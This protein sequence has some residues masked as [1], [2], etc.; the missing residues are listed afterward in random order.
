MIELPFK[1]AED[2]NSWE[3]LD[4]CE[5]CTQ[6]DLYTFF[7]YDQEG[8]SQGV[9]FAC[10]HEDACKRALKIGIERAR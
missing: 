3:G 6:A 1:E 8:E 9:C 5:E 4:I 2:L 10:K 7:D